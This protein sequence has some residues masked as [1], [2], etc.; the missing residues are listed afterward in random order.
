MVPKK[1]AHPDP[2]AVAFLERLQDRP[3]AEQFVLG[4]YFA[5][6]HYLD[7]R[8]TADVDAWWRTR[9]DPR[10][11]D[12]A[13]EAFAAA[14]AQFGYSV[15]ERSWGE[16]VSLDAVAGAENVFSFQVATRSIEIEAPIASPWGSIPIETLDENIAA[17]MSA[18]VSR[19]APRDFVD[20]KAVVDA[21]LVPLGRCWEL[22][23]VKNPGRS[24]DDAR[25]AVQNRLAGIVARTPLERLPPERRNEAAALRVWFRDVFAHEDV[26]KA[27]GPSPDGEA[28]QQ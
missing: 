17:K 25:L 24:L 12:A 18:L 4:G 10:A 16:T 21:G 9:F 11:L 26:D 6:K 5:L 8:D 3:E 23:L 13:R 15:R 28:S 7:Y 19:G 2:F 14:A 27:G 1:P 22:W 20:V